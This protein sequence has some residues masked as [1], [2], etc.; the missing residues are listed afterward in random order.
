MATQASWWKADR[1]ACF[2]HDRQACNELITIVADKVRAFAINNDV[3]NHLLLTARTTVSLRLLVVIDEAQVL[4]SL[5]RSIRQ[6][7]SA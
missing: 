7:K 5:A 6:R 3:V 1:M 4:T 2:Q